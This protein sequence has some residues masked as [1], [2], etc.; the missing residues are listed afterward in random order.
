M[1]AESVVSLIGQGKIDG[2]SEIPEMVVTTISNVFIFQEAKKVLK[3]YKKQRF[4]N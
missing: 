4:Q 3:I 1:E 2:F